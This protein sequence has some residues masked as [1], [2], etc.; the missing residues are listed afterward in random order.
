MIIVK[1]Q[2]LLLFHAWLLLAVDIPDVSQSLEYFPQLDV[3]SLS[4]PPAVE[5]GEGDGG[6]VLRLTLEDV[7]RVGRL[8]GPQSAPLTGGTLA[9]RTAQLYNCVSSTEMLCRSYK[10]FSVTSSLLN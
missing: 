6:G 5:A 3:S 10:M 9:A 8:G 2:V 7:D 1:C 4:L